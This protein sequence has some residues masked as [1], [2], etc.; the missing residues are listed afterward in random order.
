[1]YAC[2]FYILKCYAIIK[3]FRY[4]FTINSNVVTYM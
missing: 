1:M 3:T 2:F 4:L